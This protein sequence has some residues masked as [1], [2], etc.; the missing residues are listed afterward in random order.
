MS[1]TVPFAI[2]IKLNTVPQSLAICKKTSSAGEVNKTHTCTM[3][4]KAGFTASE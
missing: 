4:I 3:S 2:L 1:E